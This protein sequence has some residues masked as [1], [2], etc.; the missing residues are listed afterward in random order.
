MPVNVLLR[1]ENGVALSHTEMDANMTA[2]QDG[3]NAAHLEAIDANSNYTVAS[4]RVIIADATA[5]GFT[6]TLPLAANAIDMEFVV[7]KVD[8]SVNVVTV[9]AQGAETI[10]G[11]TTVTLTAQ[12]GKVRIFCDGIDFYLV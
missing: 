2:L 12:W 9:T 4:N 11:A 7:K 6:V 1:S 3:V 5:G 8:S 10:D